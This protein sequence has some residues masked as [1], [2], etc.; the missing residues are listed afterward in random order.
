MRILEHFW[1]SNRDWW[2]W[3]DNGNQVLKPEAPPEAQE[4]YKKYLEQMKENFT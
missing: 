2:Y 1:Q 3:D 4:S